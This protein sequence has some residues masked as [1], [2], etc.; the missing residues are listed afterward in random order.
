MKKIKLALLTVALAS[1][2][3]AAMAQDKATLIKQFIDIQR[4][5]IESLA[6]GLVEQS[7]APIAQ[8]GS[9]YLQTQVPE[10]KR[11]SA[12]KAADA[13]LK[14]YFDDAYPLVRDKAV[15]LAPGALTP[16][17][18]QN[19]S[20]DELKQLLAWINSPLSKKYQDLNPKMQTALTEKLVAETR[21]SIEP[22]MRA[23]DTNVAK[24]LGA[25]TDAPAQGSAPAKAPA[26]AS[27][28]K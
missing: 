13:E 28:K 8:A 27:T 14:K 6:R 12:A 22:K 4:P 24:A 26:K 19:F 11:E 23:L 18:E 3:M 1:S 2:S 9:Q 16:L 17:L 21:A 10:A 5:G 25:P 20:E 7:S 15:Q